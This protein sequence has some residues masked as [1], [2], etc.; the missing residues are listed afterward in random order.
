VSRLATIAREP[1]AHFLVAGRGASSRSSRCS[2]S[3]RDRPRDEIRVTRGRSRRFPRGCR[4]RGFAIPNASEL[5]DLDRRVRARG[6]LLRE[7]IALGLDKDD[8]IIRRRLRQK[9]E[10]LVRD[11]PLP[12]GAADGDPD[13]RRLRGRARRRIAA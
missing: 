6:D 8:A 11:R 7:A 13:A 2:A 3:R 9:M 5:S 10:V 1:L 12:A 4:R